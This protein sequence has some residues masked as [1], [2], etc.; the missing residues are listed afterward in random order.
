[1][2]RFRFLSITLPTMSSAAPATPRAGQ[3]PYGALARMLN[4]K[5]GKDLRSKIQKCSVSVSGRALTKKMFVYC[6]KPFPDQ[7]LKCTDISCAVVGP[8]FGRD[9]LW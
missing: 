5:L 8:R 7:P 6:R 1:M 3:C 2:G 4:F 9:I